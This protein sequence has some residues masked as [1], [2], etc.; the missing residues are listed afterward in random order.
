MM[1]AARVLRKRLTEEVGADDAEAFDR[2][3][4]KIAERAKHLDKK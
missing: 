3:L 2:A 4:E 1:K